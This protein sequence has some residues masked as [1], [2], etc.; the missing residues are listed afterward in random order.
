LPTRTGRLGEDRVERDRAGQQENGENAEREA[1]IADAVDEE[2]LDR[3][4]VGFR[5]VEPEADEQVARETHAL[6]AE[7][8]LRQI[9]GGH[10]HQHGEGEE[11]QIRE[12]S[13]LVRIVRH[14]ADRIEM[15]EAGNGRHHDQHHHGERIDA[16]RPIDLEIARGDEIED[17]DVGVMPGKADI[18][19]CVAGQHPRDG[20]QR[21]GDQLR[22]LRARGRLGGAVRLVAR[23]VDC[24]VFGLRRRRKPCAW[25]SG[26]SVAAWSSCGGGGSSPGRR[27]RAPTSVIEPAMTAPRSGRKT[28]AR[29]ISN[30]RPDRVESYARRTFL[31]GAWSFPKTGI[32]FSGS[33]AQ[34][35]IKFTSS[36]AIEPRLRK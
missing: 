25:P 35:F 10:Q 30:V 2:G 33:C 4:R 5:F 34:P 31:V 13:R 14:V 23:M 36:T 22:R 18:V 29:Y 24:G 12:E 16:Q 3:R 19:E 28:I 8:Q 26:T 20:K 9:I 17:G 6:P 32:H 21:R 27:L 1:E 11:R 7:E 15:D